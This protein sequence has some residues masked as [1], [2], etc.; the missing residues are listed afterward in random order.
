MAFNRNETNKVFY[1]NYIRNVHILKELS[2]SFLKRI[3][4]PFSRIILQGYNSFFHAR[5]YFRTNLSF[6]IF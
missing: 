5:R 2:V 3:F 4:E 1:I 6:I